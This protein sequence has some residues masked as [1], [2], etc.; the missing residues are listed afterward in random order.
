MNALRKKR[1]WTVADFAAW[2]GIKRKPALA[3]LKRLDEELG[4]TLLMTS[5]GKKP[6]Y[7]FFPAL[8][9][10][11]KPEI[12]ERVE[13]LEMRVNE[14]EERVGEISATQR[15]AIAQMGQNSRDIVRL[16]SRRPAA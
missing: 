10:K 9:A 3:L 12:F 6:E 4:S 13:G 11:A 1:L 16:Q 2:L 14:L 7:T 15:R 8:L 5:K